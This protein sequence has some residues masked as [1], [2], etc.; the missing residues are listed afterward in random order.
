MGHPPKFQT[1]LIAAFFVCALVISSCQQTTTI[2]E[3]ASNSC[4]VDH[5]SISSVQGEEDVSPMLGQNPTI[6]GTV[7]LLDPPH[8]LY[9]EQDKADD[10][11]LTS[12]GIFVSSPEL[13]SAVAQGD[14]LVISGLVAE[15]GNNKNTVTSITNLNGFRVCA[16]YQSLPASSVSLPLT[17]KQREA[18]E[19][20]HLRIEQQMVITDAYK[21]AQGLQTVNLGNLMPIPTEVARP[22]ADAR[23][24]AAKNRLTSLNIERM[25]GSVDI[26]PAGT[27][28]ASLNGVLGHDGNGLRLIQI[29]ALR[30][31]PSNLSPLAASE[32]YEIRIIG[33]NLLNYFNGDGK[34]G[35]FPT[36][37]GAKTPKDFSKQRGRLSATIKYA[38][39][40]IVAVME[41]ENDGFD[42]FSAARDFIEDL[43]NATDHRWELVQVDGTVGGDVIG[44]GLFY[45]PDLLAPAGPAQLLKTPEFERLSRVPLAQTFVE[46]GSGE[47]F[48]VVVN[49]LKSKGS[50]PADGRNTD[51]KDGQGCWNVARTQAAGKMAKW[52]KLIAAASGG[53]ALILGDMNAYRMEEPIT[54][55]IEAGFKDLKATADI[56]FEYSYIY[57]GAAGSLDHA[58][59]S[60]QLRPFVR[61]T[62]ILHINAGYPPGVEL[63]QPW[64]RSSDHDPVVVDLRFRH[65]ATLD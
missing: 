42:E 1:P 38:S 64:L 46:I 39:P 35:G 25:D 45:R 27:R 24:Q 36:P 10:S 30:V 29:E 15:I 6:V 19:G 56:G 26:L 40:H 4:D 49:H 50:C 21:A 20:M 54:A 23:A 51:L 57:G 22:G 44:V 16:S 9:M 53:K 17:G 2:T 62:R 8:G 7:T 65:S 43:E 47:S 34:G 28:L 18:L 41:L 52:S 12:N 11:D 61:S 5:I 31:I 14:R 58:F 59:A 55:I 33:I 3:L 37:R 63:P 32:E 13:A 60:P 48:L